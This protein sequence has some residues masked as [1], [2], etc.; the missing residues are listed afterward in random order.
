MNLFLV[1]VGAGLGGVLRYGVGAWI[2]SRA[3]SLFPWSTFFINVTGCFLIGVLMFLFEDR[4]RLS[5]D[6]RLFLVVGILGGYTTFS[7]YV[8][9]S[10]S[11]LEDREHRVAFLYSAGSIVVGLAAVWAGRVTVALCGL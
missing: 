11:L 9:E 1:C 4:G 5:Q 6:H 3:K 7:T 10:G 8:Y 2:Q